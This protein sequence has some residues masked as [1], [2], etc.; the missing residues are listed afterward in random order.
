MFIETYSCFFI[1]VDDLMINIRKKGLYTFT[2]PYLTFM[3][4]PAFVYCQEQKFSEIVGKYKW[5]IPLTTKYELSR[6]ENLTF[7]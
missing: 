3:C 7:L 5:I 1:F 4:L 6:L 2:V